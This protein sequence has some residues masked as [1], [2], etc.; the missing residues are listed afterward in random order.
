MSVG[1]A[2]LRRYDSA[3]G[4]KLASLFDTAEDKKSAFA[5]K[6]S[7]VKPDESRHHGDHG[8]MKWGKTMVYTVRL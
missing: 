1:I 3:L 2:T 6:P 5:T 7:G 8:M 4:K